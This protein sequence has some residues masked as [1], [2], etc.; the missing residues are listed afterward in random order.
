MRKKCSASVFVESD[1]YT[2]KL[3]EWGRIVAVLLMESV[4][5]VVVYIINVVIYIINVVDYINNDV[6]YRFE[7]DRRKFCTLV[8]QLAGKGSW[9]FGI[10]SSCLGCRRGECHVQGLKPEKRMGG[11]MATPVPW[12]KKGDGRS[13]GQLRPSPGVWFKK[14]SVCPDR[15]DALAQKLNFTPPTT[16]AFGMG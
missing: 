11:V 12:D 8:L 16:V 6:N 14:V 5:N 13:R 3:Q 7:P 10:A 4:F 15:P 9:I 1:C 2:E